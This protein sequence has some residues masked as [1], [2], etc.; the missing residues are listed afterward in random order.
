MTSPLTMDYVADVAKA[1]LKPQQELPGP[2]ALVK[3]PFERLAVL[4]AHCTSSDGTINKH[5]SSASQLRNA[6]GWWH[7]QAAKKLTFRQR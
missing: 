7:T 6:L 4:S 2:G 5:K 3:T 1:N